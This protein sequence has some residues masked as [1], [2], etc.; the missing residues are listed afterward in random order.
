MSGRCH[1]LEKVTLKADKLGGCLAKELFSCEHRAGI[2]VWKS[3]V[4]L[5]SCV[6]SVWIK[7]RLWKLD[8]KSRVSHSMLT[9]SLSLFWEAAKV[10]ID[11]GTVI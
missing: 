5:E 7:G 2:I 1:L 9:F 11:Y 6:L 4:S 8:E 3:G 10:F